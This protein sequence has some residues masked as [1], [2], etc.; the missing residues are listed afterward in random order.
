MMYNLLIILILGLYYIFGKKEE[1]IK[2]ALLVIAVN[3]LGA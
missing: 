2:F 1:F 3:S